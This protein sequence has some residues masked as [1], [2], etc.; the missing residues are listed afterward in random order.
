MRVRR[1]SGAEAEASRR[2]KTSLIV[3]PFDLFGSGGA[4]AGA[5][6]IA[7]EFREILADNRRESFAHASAGLHRSS[8]A[9]GIHL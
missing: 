7:D 2:M 4:G 3:F 9:Q 8:A 5:A 6:L 1:R